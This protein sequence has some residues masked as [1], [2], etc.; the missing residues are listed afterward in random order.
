MYELVVKYQL[1]ELKMYQ[2]M[3]LTHCKY[4]GWREDEVQCPYSGQDYHCRK[5]G[6]RSTRPFLP[7]TLVEVEGVLITPSFS[8]LTST[9]MDDREYGKAN[10]LDRKENITEKNN[11]SDESE[12]S[13]NDSNDSDSD[14]PPEYS[15]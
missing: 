7:P 6:R 13:E 8:P 14:E 5:E 3:I 11:D 4:Q 1:S 9:V 2:N 12:F 15:G 10:G